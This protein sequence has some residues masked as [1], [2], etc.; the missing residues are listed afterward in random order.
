VNAAFSFKFGYV[1]QVA[2]ILEDL[3]TQL[4]IK[5]TTEWIQKANFSSSLRNPFKVGLLM[6]PKSPEVCPCLTNSSDLHAMLVNLLF[7]SQ[8]A[9]FSEF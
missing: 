2:K 3:E 8:V 4:G 9:V 7:P 6:C 1:G 5:P